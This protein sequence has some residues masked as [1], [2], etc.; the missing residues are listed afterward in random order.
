MTG[1]WYIGGFLVAMGVL[2][3][4]HEFGHFL[5]ARLCGVRVLRF[6]LGF[7][8]PIRVWQRS[9]G[10]TEWAVSAI[11]LGGY[12]K[13]L[14]EREGPVP[15]E[16]L[17]E[18]FNRKPVGQRIAIVLAGPVANLVLAVAIYF[19]LLATGV[20]DYRPR[21]AAPPA[22]SPAAVAGVQAGDEVVRA[23][24]RPI[25]T[26]S[27]LRWLVI[28]HAVD[29]EALQLSTRDAQGVVRE[30]LLP[31]RGIVFD[32]GAQDLVQ[33]LGLVLERPRLPPVVGALVA[34]GPAERAGL[35][36]DDRFVALDGRAVSQFGDIVEIVSAA[37]GR[38]I[39][40]TIARGSRTFETRLTPGA[41][42]EGERTVG[43]IGVAPKVDPAWREQVFVDARYPLGE[44]LVRA[45][46]QTY[47]T[48]KLS[49]VMM[50][51]M[52]TG[53]IALSNISGP[54]AIADY[55]GQSARM[56]FEPYLRFLALVSISIG[57]LNLLPVPLLDGGHIMYYLAEILM[58]RPVST[59]TMELGQQVGFVLLAMLMAF[60]FFND[61][62][63][64]F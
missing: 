2:V 18:A 55:A 57:V 26:W 5:V 6:S 50:G 63:R 31:T 37:P 38:E 28:S 12:V 13:M 3:T 53:D 8:A 23:G 9:P 42:S 46:R 49:F 27:D 10:S 54:V 33:Q 34:E 1:L 60:A 45:C 15:P 21:L 17:G 56:G 20:S 30:R 7:G 35:R 41:Q 36:V 52:L 22:G 14:D 48:A 61:L 44:S 62:R 59:R 4:I 25:Q 19:G 58:R 16:L 64:W 40:A 24:G 51:R 39:V 11:P 47:E 29:A 32:G 43:R